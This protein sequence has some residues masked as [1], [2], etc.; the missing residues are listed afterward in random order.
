[1]TLRWT[2]MAHVR[3]LA[4]ELLMLKALSACGTARS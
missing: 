2:W 1:M 3:T 4:A